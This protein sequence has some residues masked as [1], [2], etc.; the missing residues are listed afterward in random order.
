MLQQYFGLHS[1]SYMQSSTVAQW[2]LK[3]TQAPDYSPLKTTDVEIAHV[4]DQCTLHRIEYCLY[5]DSV[6]SGT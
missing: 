3:R 5:V 2:H 6:F 4:R 1:M